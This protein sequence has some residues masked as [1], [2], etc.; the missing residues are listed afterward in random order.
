MV[1][2]FSCRIGHVAVRVH[3]YLYPLASSP[4]LQASLLSSVAAALEMKLVAR[5][6]ALAASGSSPAA[7][8]EDLV[9]SPRPGEP[10]EPARGTREGNR[11]K[12]A[13]QRQAQEPIFASRSFS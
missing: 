11:L 2:P 1:T 8:A 6:C 4:T 3:L 12:P 5:L 13:R 9:K 10:G 7:S